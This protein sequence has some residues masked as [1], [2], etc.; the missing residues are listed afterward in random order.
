MAKTTKATILRQLP[1]AR[2]HEARERRTGRRAVSA[3]YDA[4]AD[5]VMLELTSGFVFGFPPR[6]IP[7]L[8]H[9]SAAELA[10]MRLSPG[11]GALHWE[12]LDVDLSVPGLLLASVDRPA[13]LRELARLAGR[14]RSGAKAAAA[15][16]NGAKGGRPRKAAS[17]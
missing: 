3:H 17:S 7:A 1:V 9:A 10:A 2:A 12:T 15:R 14:T 5:R 6:A 13:R 16:A 8:A 4:E 11:G